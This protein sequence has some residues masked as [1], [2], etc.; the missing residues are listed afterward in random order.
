[1]R[2]NSCHTR[3]GRRW[4]NARRTRDV[5]SSS[6]SGCWWAVY[7]GFL[8]GPLAAATGA[9]PAGSAANEVRSLAT[10][11][12]AARSRRGRSPDME[13]AVAGRAGVGL[14]SPSCDRGGAALMAERR[15]V[16]GSGCAPLS[17]PRPFSLI[18]QTALSSGRSAQFEIGTIRGGK[19]GRCR[20]QTSGRP[21]T[22]SPGDAVIALRRDRPTS[23]QAPKTCV[24]RN[25]RCSSCIASGRT[26]NQASRS[27]A[28]TGGAAPG[29]IPTKKAIP[30]GQSMPR[31]RWLGY[32][33]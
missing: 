5:R 14:T 6:G 29:E 13:V 7:A 31:S 18:C 32:S 33:M 11:S 17:S 20:W 1:M 12:A 3:P 28:R 16:P 10:R 23:G 25:V 22:P 2:P 9:P 27:S 8:S 26:V 21:S 15:Q 24:V 19:P 4:W 30:I